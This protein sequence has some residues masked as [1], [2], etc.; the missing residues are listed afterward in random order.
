MRK[1]QCVS[2]AILISLP[3]LIHSQSLV[4]CVFVA[5]SSYTLLVMGPTA[6]INSISIES[7]GARFSEYSPEYNNLKLS[8]SG[9]SIGW[10][11]EQFFGRIKRYPTYSVL[12]RLKYN[13]YNLSSENYYPGIKADT[14]I[15]TG[16]ESDQDA[17]LSR[18]EQKLTYYDL[19]VT[20][21]YFIYRDFSLSVGPNIACI[22]TDN[23]METLEIRNQ[24]QGLYKFKEEFHPIRF[25]GENKAVVYDGEPES[26]RTFLF[27]LDF[28]INYDILTQNWVFKPY[29]GYSFGLNS[30]F[31]DF[32]WDTR[33][34]SAGIMI[35]YAFRF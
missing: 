35:Q 29:V 7:D 20:F 31:K 19:D 3:G 26:G 1:W 34:W 28:F 18:V 23:I 22:L 6:D 10:N 15:L 4:G 5:S 27:A 13:N 16:L 12:F 32:K 25:D 9:Y 24:Y 2:V 33:S 30:I 14:D 17:L 21:N 11:Y 8:G